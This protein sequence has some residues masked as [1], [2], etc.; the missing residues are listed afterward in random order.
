MNV[1][2]ILRKNPTAWERFVMEEDYEPVGTDEHQ[3]TLHKYSRYKDV[4]D[5]SVSRYLVNNG[6]K[7]RYPGGRNFAVCL[8]HDIDGIYCKKKRLLYSAW[9]RIV[10]GKIRECVQVLT[11]TGM[12]PYNNL[13]EIVDVE[14]SY[15]ASSSFYFLSL[16]KGH[17]DFNYSLSEV[18]DSMSYIMDHGCE[19]GLHGSYEASMDAEQLAEERGRLEEVTGVKIMGYR[20]HFLRFKVP[21]SW[22]IL[23]SAGF[24]YDTTYGYPDMVGF[25]NGMC[26]PFRPYNL[27]K[28]KTVDILEIP[29]EI[30]DKTLFEYMGLDQQG[31]WHYIEQLLT[32]VEEC[33]GVLTVLFHNPYLAKGGLAIYHRFL[34]LCREK[35]AWMTSGKEIWK[36][37]KSIEE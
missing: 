20:N 33:G 21:D 18:M 22:E 31:A 34:N 30:M 17:R 36:H 9:K 2:D 10:R 7:V 29:L 35:N 14:E 8:T 23:S 3:R 5:P 26:H 37:F 6:L 13:K 1:H 4:L 16:E 27:G 15:D 11:D 24:K 12:D 19:V 32:S 25:R 28:R